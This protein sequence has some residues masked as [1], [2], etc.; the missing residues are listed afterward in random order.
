MSVP[1][2]A[3]AGNV[4]G[5]MWHGS[6][7]ADELRGAFLAAVL[8][9]APS[10]VSFAA[11]RARRFDLPGDLIAFGSSAERI[12]SPSQYGGKACPVHCRNTGRCVIG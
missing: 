7:E 4:F 8:G 3:R 5:T 12:P 9:R 10:A 11:A 6:L 2:S 1:A